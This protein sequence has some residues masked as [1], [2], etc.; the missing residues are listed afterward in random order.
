MDCCAFT[1]FCGLLLTH[2]IHDI[3]DGYFTLL[4]K[5]DDS[6]TYEYTLSFL[7]ILQKSSSFIKYYISF[8][9]IQ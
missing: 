8:L 7:S 5:D 3:L 4:T 6:L 9:I 2:D 1:L